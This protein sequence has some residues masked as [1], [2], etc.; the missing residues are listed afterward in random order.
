MTQGPAGWLGL[1]LTGGSNYVTRPF[2]ET[3]GP[4]GHSTAAR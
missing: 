4:G 2:R 1:R 3:G